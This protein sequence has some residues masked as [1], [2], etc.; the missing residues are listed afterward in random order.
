MFVLAMCATAAWT[1]AQAEVGGPDPERVGVDSAQQ[2]LKEVSVDKF[3]ND[4]YWLSSMST[5]EG[6]TTTRL[7]EGSPLSKKPIEAEKDM[8]LPDKMV[9]GTRVDFLRRGH[10]SFVVYPVKPIPIEGITKTISVWVAGR[11]YNH[12][13]KIIVR[14]FFGN[15]FELFVG[16]LTFQGWK[17]MTVAIPPQSPDGQSGIIQRNYHYNNH[18][19]IKVVGFKI[20]CDPMEAY[21]S[22][23]IYFDDLRAV[24]DLFAEDDRARRLKDP[25]PANR[26]DDMVDFW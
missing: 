20:E 2:K 16:K 5:D 25:D 12:V 1:F 9:L 26:D 23:Y 6:Y 8:S 13:L 7:F 22:Y 11:N 14:D 15:E 21:G 18:M 4:G 10:S 19:G 3:E 17:Q 24:A